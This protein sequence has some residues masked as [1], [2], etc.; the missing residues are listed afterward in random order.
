MLG[1]RDLTTPPVE[2]FFSS[3]A[4]SR[5]ALRTVTSVAPVSE[6]S[7]GVTS[8]ALLND[9]VRAAILELCSVCVQTSFPELCCD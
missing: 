1:L 5:C 3:T 7:L 8:P 9:F 2:V 6:N 4:D